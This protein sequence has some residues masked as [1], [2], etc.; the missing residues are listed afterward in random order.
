MQAISTAVLA[1]LTLWV[2]LFSEVGDLAMQL[3]RADL[4]ETK[5]QMQIVHQ[6]KEALEDERKRLQ[7]ERNELARE[8]E[9]HVA[10]L[11]N[12]RLGEL[13]NVGVQALGKYRTVAEL[14]QD[15]LAEAESVEQYR[16][17]KESQKEVPIKSIWIRSFPVPGIQT[18]KAARSGGSF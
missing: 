16:D 2:I 18:R 8:R 1:L 12:A 7:G 17:W 6:E 14:G 4:V 5:E 10:Q 3:L 15:L 11:V 9:E 13:W